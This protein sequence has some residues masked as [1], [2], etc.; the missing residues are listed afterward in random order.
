MCTMCV[1]LFMFHPFFLDVGC[2]SFWRAC[3]VWRDYLNFS[4]WDYFRN[5][6]FLNFIPLLILALVIKLKYSND[7]NQQSSLGALNE[8]PTTLLQHYTWPESPVVMK[9]HSTF[10]GW[11]FLDSDWD[12]TLAWTAPNTLNRLFLKCIKL[13]LVRAGPSC[14]LEGWTCS[15]FAATRLPAC[16]LTLPSVAR[17]NWDFISLRPPLLSLILSLCVASSHRGE[18]TVEN[19]RYN[20]F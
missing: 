1:Y 14:G 11:H 19:W 16:T 15:C 17:G 3:Y 18:C 7:Q 13:Y 8:F 9:P 4:N 2:V 10:P 20:T 6:T 5:N 12:F